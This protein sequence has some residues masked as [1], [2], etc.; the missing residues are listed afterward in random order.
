M[1]GPRFRHHSRPKELETRRIPWPIRLHRDSTPHY[2]PLLILTRLCRPI[3]LH[4]SLRLPVFA[5]L[6]CITHPYKIHIPPLCVLRYILRS[7]MP[8]HLVRMARG[9]EPPLISLTCGIVFPQ[10]LTPTSFSD[11]T[12]YGG[13][14]SI[15]QR[16]SRHSA[17]SADLWAGAAI[18]RTPSQ[19]HLTDDHLS[20][21]SQ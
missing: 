1:N 10:Q 4:H 2:R 21:E 9:P 16:D 6:V 5:P 12:G 13:V 18:S 20:S 11:Y 15:N 3:L 17:H 14:S 7:A 8:L 19:A